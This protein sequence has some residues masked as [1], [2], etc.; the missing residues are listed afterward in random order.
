MTV[1]G[2]KTFLT[3]NIDDDIIVMFKKAIIYSLSGLS[4][5]KTLH[6]LVNNGIL[7][8][9]MSLSVIL[10]S[11]SMNPGKWVD[12]CKGSVSEHN[13]VHVPSVCWM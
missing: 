6:S 11:T 9:G 8:L 12:L 13:R 3:V 5:C 2:H 10:T 1:Y 7:F 4:A